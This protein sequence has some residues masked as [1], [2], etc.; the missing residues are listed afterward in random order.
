M[1]SCCDGLPDQ[2]II[3]SSN[4]AGAFAGAGAGA[5]AVDCR[6]AESRSAVSIAISSDDSSSWHMGSSRGSC[7]NFASWNSAMAR[8]SGEL[9]E[10]LSRGWQQ[11][12]LQQQQWQQHRWPQQQ[13]SRV[14]QQHLRQPPPRG[15]VGPGQYT[16]RY[17]EAATA[18]ETCV[19][20]LGACIVSGPVAS[21]VLSVGD[22][23]TT[24]LV[25]A[26]VDGSGATSPTAQLS[27]TLDSGASSCFFH[28]CTDLTPLHTPVTVALSDPSMGSVV[29]RSTTTL[30]CPT[31]PSGFLIGY[32]TPSFSWNLV[33]VSHLH[34]LGFVTTF[35]LGK[36]V[37]SCTVGATGAPLA[38]FRREPGSGLYS[39]HTGLGQVRPSQLAAESCDC[40]SLTHPSVLWHHRLGHPSFPRLS[41][42]VRHRLVSSLLESL[43]PLPRSPAPPCTP[44]VEGWQCAAPH[45]SSF[46][47]TIA[48]LQTLHLDVWGLSPVLGPRQERYFLIVVDDY[49]RFTTIF[50]LRRKAKIPTVLEPWLLA[51]GGAQGLCGL[52]LHS[53]RGGEFSSTRL[54]MFCQGREII[55]SYTLPDSPQQNR[56]AERR[57]G[58]VMEVAQTS[59]CHAGAPQIVWPLAVRYAAH[60]LNLWPSDARPRVTSISLWTGWLFYNPAT[61]QLFASQD[62]TFVESVSYYRIRPHRGSEAFAPPLFLTPEPPPPP[63][64]SPV[65][66]VAPSSPP[67]RHVL[68]VSGGA[69]GATA[70]GGGSR[71]ARLGGA[72]SGVAEGVRLET[73]PVE[74]TIVLTRRSSPTS[75]LGFP[76]VPQFPPRSTL[77][78]LAAEPGGVPA[79]GTGDTG[80]VVVGGS[81]SGGAGAVDTGTTTP[82]LRTLRFLTRMQRLDQLE[83]EERERFERARQQQQQSQLEHQERVEEESQPHQ[84]RVEEEGGVTAI[85][86]ESRGGFTTAAAGAV[87]A[88]EGESRGGVTTAAAGAV[89]ATAGES[90]AGV[91]PT[92]EGAVATAPGEDKAGVPA[93]AGGV[94][95]AMARESRGGATG[96]AVGSLSLSQW[97]RRSPLSRALS[98]EPRRSRYRADG[99]FH[100]ILLS[101]VPPPLVLPNP[102]ESSL[103]VFHDPLSDY[104]RAS[105]PIVSPVLSALVTHSTA[106]PLSVSALVTT[107]SVFAFSHRLD[108]A[109]HLVS[110]T[111]R[112]QSSGGTPVLPLK[113]LEDGQLDIGFL[114][115]VV[116]HP[117][118]MLL[119]PE[120]DPDALNIPI[121]R[122]HTEAVSGPWALYWIADEE[123][124]M[125]SYRSTGTYVD[126]V[127]PPG[128]NVVSGMWLYKVKRPPGSPPVFKARYVATCFIQREGVDFFQTFAPTPKMTTLRGSLHEQ[129]WLR[130][131]PGFT[132]S[133]PPGIQWQLHRL[134]YSF[135]QAPREWHNTLRTTLAA[136]DFFRSSADPSLFV[137]HGSTL[138]FVLVYVDDLVFATPDR[139]ALASVKEELQRRHTCSD[140]GEL[141]CYPGLQITTDRAA[142][143]LR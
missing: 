95:A 6:W 122:N 50:T 27:F 126:A 37:A 104:L 106:P 30:P 143:T 41:R 23:A 22:A 11:Q 85:V 48:P 135:C 87:A 83:R 39:L 45:S 84:E 69:D 4:C 35:P 96:A 55:Q 18:I 58:L 9:S 101:C 89:A 20:S 14:Q 91:P 111:A 92:A 77:R 117:C 56:V 76:S 72:G 97:T 119:A 133:F 128:M 59:M 43:A 124:E 61:H 16:H 25:P 86:G 113:V 2:M 32:Y 67:Q 93:A 46:P 52:R 8:V 53:D 110:G 140:L 75:P 74:D 115:A 33:G 138:F 1:M 17:V 10:S 141:Q 108:Y 54:E 80:G 71:A 90:R 100:L 137:R 88:A 47:P 60:Q 29:A 51:R 5:F 21:E 99:L 130:R 57:I 13:Q 107:V 3:H 120:G 129:I 28:D 127:P 7:V 81:G 73:F 114:V 98:P 40:W 38:T 82:T 102:P 36:P 121:P 112:S 132:G 24:S 118:A 66:P 63:P 31:A 34:D 105:C 68:V 109:A 78:P 94:V 26:F 42:M 70:E 123:E 79:G 142:R 64:P 49:S 139:H 116:P 65:P 134:V 44:C 103:T 15:P 62:V 12:W 19:S 131:L 136:L 125:A